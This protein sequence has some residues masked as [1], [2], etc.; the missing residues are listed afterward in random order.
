MSHDDESMASRI[1]TDLSRWPLAIVTFPDLVVTDEDVRSFVDEQRAMLHRKEP[2]VVITDARKA[3]VISPA[4]RKMLV[5]WLTEAEPL[6]KRYTL[7]M[8]I[9][10]DSAIVR[11]ALTAVMWMKE[12]PVPIKTYGSLR[13]A[14][15][16]V[17][18]VLR[19]RGIAMAGVDAG[20]L[21]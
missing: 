8:S 10:I 18:G 2:H 4:Q 3:R 19:A 15:D 11:G 13:E 17:L 9:V 12:P 1:L 7:A 5:D 20:S 6:N 21:R 16:H 14:G